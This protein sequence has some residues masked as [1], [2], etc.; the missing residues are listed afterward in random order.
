[1]YLGTATNNRVMMVLADSSTPLF[2]WCPPCV[3]LEITLFVQAYRCRP[4]A[5]KGLEKF[6]PLALHTES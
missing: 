6:G 1:M 5:S 3:V 2:Q 4:R